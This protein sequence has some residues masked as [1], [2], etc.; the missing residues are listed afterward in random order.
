MTRL[1]RILAL[2]I[3]LLWPAVVRADDAFSTA[4]GNSTATTGTGRQI[5]TRGKMV[6]L[7][8]KGVAASADGTFRVECAAT[9][10]TDDDDWGICSD[11]YSIAGEALVALSVADSNFTRVRVVTL[12]AGS[13]TGT[14]ALETR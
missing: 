14:F 8:V 4:T 3:C 12:T 6:S 10:S 2:A 11:D 7:Y 5:D 13:V 9:D 1:L